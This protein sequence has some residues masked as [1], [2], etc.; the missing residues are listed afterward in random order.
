MLKRFVLDSVESK[1][2]KTIQ[3]YESASTF[4]GYGKEILIGERKDL[5]MQILDRGKRMFEKNGERD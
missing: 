4:S 2:M 5:I 3:W 1:S